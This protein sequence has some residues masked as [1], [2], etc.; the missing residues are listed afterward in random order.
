MRLSAEDKSRLS[1]LTYKIKYL[2]AEVKAAKTEWQA[3][4]QVRAALAG[5][6]GDIE[7]NMETGVISQK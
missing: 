3:F 6:T 2:E 7:V 5:I 4:L 1:E